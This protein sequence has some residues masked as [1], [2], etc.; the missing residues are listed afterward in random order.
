VQDVTEARLAGSEKG[1]KVRE[2]KAAKH[3]DTRV[4]TMIA[5]LEVLVDKLH[6]VEPP[7]TQVPLAPHVVEQ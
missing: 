2:T 7:P 3:L 5:E 1:V 6:S 4:D